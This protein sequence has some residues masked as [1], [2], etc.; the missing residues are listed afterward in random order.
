MSFL[1]PLF[2]VAG[3]SM[4]I[5]ILIHL[6]NLR[7]YKTIYFPHTRFLKDIQLS[8][9]KQSQVRYK[10]LLAMRL[11]FLAF[12]I[13]AFAQPFF[14]RSIETSK[15]NKLQ[16]IYLD[17]SYSM[18]VK[19]GV[20]SLLEIAKESALRQVLHA[21]VGA[22][23]ILLTNDKP[24]SYHPETA[25]KVIEHI[26]STEISS[27]VKTVSQILAYSHGIMHNEGIA[28]ADLYY[29]SDFQQNA[30]PAPPDKSLLKDITFYALPLKPD[31]VGDVSIDTAFF[32]I[33][34]LQS[35]K[36]NLLVV[37]THLIGKPPKEQPVLQ[38]VV[39][40]QVKSATTL[41]FSGKPDSYDTLGFQV[42]DAGW[43]QIALSLNDA[44]VR[45]NDTFCIAA[46]NNKNLSVLVLN[47]GQMNP[48]IQ[49]AFRVYDGFRLNQEDIASASKDWKSYNLI[50]LNG[51]TRIDE[52]TGKVMNDALQTGKSICIFPGRTQNFIAINDG[53]K[54]MGDITITGIDTVVQT[55]GNL[56]EGS[57]LVKDI[58]EKIPDNVQL[59]V[60]NWHYSF[61]SGLSANRL[62]IISF[63]NGDPYLACYTPSKGKLY[64][65]ANAADLQSGNFI[66]SY[67]FAPF[68][69]EMALQSG[70][71]NIYA[72]SAG[73]GQP[74]YVPLQDATERNTAHL[75]GK[76]MDIIP[77]Q[78]SEGAGLDVFIDEAIRQPGFY[79][80]SVADNDTFTVALNPD[81]HELHLEYKD[82]NAL[83]NDWKGDNIHWV[84]ISESGK[85][86][87]NKDNDF[88]LWK[89]CVILALA[90]L[91]FETWLLARKIRISANSP[92]AQTVDH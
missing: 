34:S 31:E 30:F 33:P 47:E 61:T 1:Y 52:A 2:L 38:L 51:I 25:D 85:I 59:P 22:K 27:S 81:I 5:P 26:N 46:R 72:V 83:K 75:T 79:K 92:V 91:A 48:Y 20:R 19:N 23:F 8:S 12:L 57:N 78:R 70:S 88:P 69:Y 37:H 64:M 13:S 42:S 39:N 86:N 35:G 14:N 60:A 45:F 41:N 77:P 44:T 63:R 62:S 58:F 10:L 54:L 82:I 43:Q 80:L 73:S 74:I 50:I 49:A 67:F 84:S 9:R 24:L 18:S 17:N 29:F 66:G 6:F 7:R 68:L 4:A 90:A 36:N 53:L 16:V 15:G 71:G 3:V 87:D 76:D 89:V 11:L 21:R 65:C 32:M 28:T 56:Q 40:G 55:A